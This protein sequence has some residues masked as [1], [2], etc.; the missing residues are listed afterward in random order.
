MIIVAAGQGHR[1]GGL[2]QFELLAGRPVHEWSVAA[3]R[4][5]ADGVVLVVP[6]GLVDDRALAAGVDKVVAG[7]ATRAASVRAGLAAVPETARIVLVHDAVRPLAS[8]SLFGAVVAALSPGGADGADGADGAV[9]GLPLVDTV[10]QVEGRVVKATL[11]RERL[12]R[13]QTPQGFR[14]EWLRRAHSAGADATDD[15][16]L[17]EALGGR[18][19][20]VPGEE[21][22][23]K[24]TSR[25]DLAAAEERLAARAP[26]GE[27]AKAPVT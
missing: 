5:A 13:V 6:P 19:V 15:A 10:K 2:K 25:A 14:A 8:P 20:V 26:Q 22:N 17:V 12:V 18:V 23:L 11:D 16:A 9:P 24:I 27:R 3:A 1:Y 4:E 7:G 21:G